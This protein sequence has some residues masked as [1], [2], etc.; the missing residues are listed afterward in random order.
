MN[1]VHEDGM[2]STDLKDET[3]L[4]LDNMKSLQLELAAAYIVES[5]TFVDNLSFRVYITVINE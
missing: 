2:H 1:A 3:S 5:L 4:E